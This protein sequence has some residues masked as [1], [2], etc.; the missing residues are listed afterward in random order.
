MVGSGS[1]W[2]S[3]RNGAPTRGSPSRASIL[4]RRN[5]IRRADREGARRLEDHGRGKE[6]E[7]R[8]LAM[9]ILVGL[10]S[11][12]FLVGCIVGD[13]I[14][15]IT[16]EPDGSAEVV[17]FR[18]NLR[19]SESG[20][21]AEQDVQQ[22]A[23]SFDAGGSPDHDRIRAA[24]GTIVDSRWIRR[25]TPSSNLISAKLPTAAVLEKYFTI[26]GGDDELRLEARFTQEGDRRRLAL[27]LHPPKDFKLPQPVSV[28][29]ARQGQADD[30]SETR[31]A[32]ANGTIER[33]RGFTVA[34]DRRSAL[35]ALD[36]IA[37]LVRADPRRV[38]LFL[39]WRVAGN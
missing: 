31:L 30:L 11:A 10:A 1:P 35:L 26:H 8:R 38:E 22:Y 27:V 16:L 32:V 17:L 28:K 7:M 24:G 12:A 2:K 5:A 19:S 13:E 36:E 9:A 23:E 6:I 37:E 39:E 34:S 29:E 14:T 15:T 21:K 20:A 4:D 3:R 25:A 33:A 18:S